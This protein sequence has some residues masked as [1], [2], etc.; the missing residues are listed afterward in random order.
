MYF[1]KWDMYW[2]NFCGFSLVTESMKSRLKIVPFSNERH[3][4]I[5]LQFS[6]GN[7]LNYKKKHNF[8]CDSS[9]KQRQTRVHSGPI[10][11]PLKGYHKISWR[12]VPSIFKKKNEFLHEY[13][14]YRY[15][16][17][18][19]GLSWKGYSFLKIQGFLF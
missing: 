17:S 2:K 1:Y 9:L 18:C 7:Y 12:E 6:E 4:E 8:A 3:F 11:L 15:T 19:K 16:L 5:W 14:P 10:T 13:I